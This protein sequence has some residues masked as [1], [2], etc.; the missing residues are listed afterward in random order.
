MF[1][2]ARLQFVMYAEAAAKAHHQHGGR[3]AAVAASKK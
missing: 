1:L 2:V 3:P